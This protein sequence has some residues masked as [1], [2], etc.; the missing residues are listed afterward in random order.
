MAKHRTHEVRQKGRK[1]PYHVGTITSEQ[2]RTMD[3]ANRR[4]EQIESGINLASGSGVHGGGKRDR[5]RKD[6]REGRQQVR[7]SDW[8]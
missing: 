7:N 2:L 4:Q 3:R 5:N 8:S 6:R 1:D